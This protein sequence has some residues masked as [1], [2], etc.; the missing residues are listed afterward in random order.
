MYF[1]DIALYY[2]VLL[3]ALRVYVVLTRLNLCQLHSRCLYGP[4]G[5]FGHRGSLQK[6]R[7]CCAGQESPG[8]W[9]PLRF[10]ERLSLV[11]VL[12]YCFDPVGQTGPGRGLSVHCSPAGRGWTSEAVFPWAS[13]AGSD[14]RLAQ[15]FPEGP[16]AARGRG[17]DLGHGPAVLRAARQEFKR[18]ALL[19]QFPSERLP[20]VRC[21]AMFLCCVSNG[22]FV[23]EHMWSVCVLLLSFRCAENKMDSSN[24][25]VI[26]APNLFHCGDGGD[27]LSSS[28][29]KRLKHQAAAVQ[30]LIDN[31]QHLGM[32]AFHVTTSWKHLIWIWLIH[33]VVNH[34]N[35]TFPL[36]QH[37]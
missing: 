34:V 10:T 26:F 14:R 9:S 33:K 11:A 30:C 6:V 16:G 37:W 24:L 22:S 25:S 21:R 12:T 23:F 1:P 31:A 27:K 17:E 15:C 35:Q 4:H 2:I 3:F 5:S 8:E 36:C 13:R 19:L 20:A 29:E 28:T 7:L 32:C 18:T